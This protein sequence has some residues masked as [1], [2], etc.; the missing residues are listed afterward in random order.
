MSGVNNNPPWVKH[1]LPVTAVN[2]NRT[3]IKFL[4]W[5][6]TGKNKKN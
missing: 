1:G 4:V 6:K 3:K 5:L 2:N